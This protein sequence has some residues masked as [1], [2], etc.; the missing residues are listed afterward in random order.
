[1]RIRSSGER[2]SRW[3][4]RRKSEDGREEEGRRIEG[5]K[6]KTEVVRFQ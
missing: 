3:N 2:W 5:K 6:G 4:R 1:M